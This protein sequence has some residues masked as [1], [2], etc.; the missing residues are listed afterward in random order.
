MV[1]DNGNLFHLHAN[2]TIQVTDSTTDQD[3]LF[4]ALFQNCAN[5]R[6]GLSAMPSGSLRRSCG[7]ANRCA[8]RLNPVNIGIEKFPEE[9]VLC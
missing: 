8:S 6:T 2:D 1:E 5:D 4:H 7:S 9:T 3:I